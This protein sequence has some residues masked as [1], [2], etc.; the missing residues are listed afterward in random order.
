[1]HSMCAR[2][3]SCWGDSHGVQNNCSHHDIVSMYRAIILVNAVTLC[4][5]EQKQRQLFIKPSLRYADISHTQAYPPQ[6][7]P[8]KQQ[9]VKHTLCVAL[10]HWG[11][12]GGQN[13]HGHRLWQGGDV[14]GHNWLLGE[15]VRDRGYSRGGRR[16]RPLW[17]IGICLQHGMC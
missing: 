13:R 3:Q 11:E 2:K 1:M 8:P 12:E 14:A 17:L 10:L 16:L 4:S 5:S 7:Y 6:A 9:G 15:E